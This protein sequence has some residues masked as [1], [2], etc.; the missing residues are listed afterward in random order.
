MAW[1]PQVA[2]LGTIIFYQLYL[3]LIWMNFFVNRFI[4][5]IV[6]NV[7]NKV[8][9]YKFPR[10]LEIEKI[11]DRD[12]FV[13]LELEYADNYLRS[14]GVIGEN[15][16]CWWCVFIALCVPCSKEGDGRRREFSDSPNSLISYVTAPLYFVMV[17]IFLQILLFLLK[18]L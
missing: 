3:I 1:L 4:Q 12:F 15:M 8:N 7:V 6:I 2:F 10:N 11:Y 14:I 16:K 17:L 13:D 5:Y 9:V 18:F